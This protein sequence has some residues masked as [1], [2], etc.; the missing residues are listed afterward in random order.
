M[1]TDLRVRSATDMR[2]PLDGGVEL[3]FS[4]SSLG[5]DQAAAPVL[6]DHTPEPVQRWDSYDHF[7]TTATDLAGTV[8]QPAVLLAHVRNVHLERRLLERPKYCWLMVVD[9]FLVPSFV[10]AHRSAFHISSE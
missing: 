7:R 2:F 9:N 4:A 3:H 5:Q 10:K 1:F 6:V 8:R